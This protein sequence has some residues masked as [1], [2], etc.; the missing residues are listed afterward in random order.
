MMD[1]QDREVNATLQRRETS[2]H[3]PN[4]NVD[5]RSGRLDPPPSRP[6]GKLADNS[7]VSADR[8]AQDSNGH[9][10][11]PGGPRRSRRLAN[12]YNGNAAVVRNATVA[13]TE[14]DNAQ[15]QEPAQTSGQGTQPERRT[16][17]KEK[18][19]LDF[20]QHDSNG[21]ASLTS[22]HN[23]VRSVVQTDHVPHQTPTDDTSASQQRPSDLTS[24]AS[25][26]PMAPTTRSQDLTAALEGLSLDVKPPTQPKVKPLK[27]PKKPRPEKKPTKRAATTTTKQPE[28]RL[29]IMP[30]PE[31]THAYLHQAHQPPLGTHTFRPLLIIL[32]LN[33]TLLKRKHK[34]GSAFH[35][36]PGLQEFL[37]YLFTHHR[38]MVWSSARRENV[39]KICRSA[40]TPAQLDALVAIWSRED[41]QLSEEAFKAHSQVYKQLSWV[42]RHQ[43]ISQTS[44]VP[45]EVWNQANTVLIDDSTL[46][47]ASEPFNLLEVP[48]FTNA[49]VQEREDVLMEVWRYLNVLG[50]QQDVSAYMRVRPFV[51]DQAAVEGQRVGWEWEGSG[52]W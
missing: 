20:N 10:P 48:E 50:F 52:R 44:P 49:I 24:A 11:E 34:G 36:R 8:P 42:W 35:P 37:E 51:Y 30:R 33:G 22:E 13:S 14:T 41:L 3:P 39:I 45:G 25:A 4:S 46:K 32:D 7:D 15:V 18:K 6:G 16:L 26:E 23:P 12:K 38:V 9:R 40:F 21:V 2:E 28:P 29:D 1:T 27:E 47:A 5:A 43:L 17:A 19:I 31:P